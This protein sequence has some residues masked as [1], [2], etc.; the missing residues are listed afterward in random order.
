MKNLVKMLKSSFVTRMAFIATVFA[1][2]LASSSCKHDKGGDKPKPKDEVVVLTFKKG[3]NVT[4]INP[5][6]IQVPKGTSIKRS[7]LKNKIT[8]MTFAAGYE[9]D[10]LCVGA[11][12]GV[13]ITESKPLV[14]S[15]NT[16]IYVVAKQKGAVDPTL[17]TLTSVKVSGV[18]IDVADDMKAGDT[19]E[20]QVDVEFAT[21]P[22]DAT[23]S[24]SPNL[25]P[26]DASQKKGKWKLEV[27]KKTLTITVAKDG[28]TKEYSLT[29]ERL[30]A[31]APRLTS[32]KVDDV[33]VTPITDEMT[34]P[35]TQKEKVKV[36]YESAPTGTTV[37]TTPALNAGEWALQDGDNT[38]VIKVKK[39]ANEKEYKLKITKGGNVPGGDLQIT[40]ITV[41]KGAFTHKKEGDAVVEEGTGTIEI[42][43]PTEFDGVEYDL[44]LAH[45]EGATVEY[46]STDAELKT[47]LEGGKVKFGKL[48]YL[49]DLSKEF[50][51]KISKGGE[52]KTY[53]VKVIMMTNAAGFFGAR[54]NGKDTSANLDTIIKVLN[55][56]EPTLEI[57]GHEAF[58]VFVS[59]V[60]KWKT[61]LYNK[62]NAKFDLPPGAR[63]KGMG[64]K[65]I[66]LGAPGTTTDVEVII[67]NSEY[68]NDKPKEPWLATEVLKFKVK[69]TDTKADAFINQVLVNG[70]NVTN[71]EN[72]PE[73]FTAL[74]DTTPP[75][76]DSGKKASVGVVLSKKVQSV[77]IDGQAV[78]E[79]EWVTKA[80][81]GEVTVVKKDIDVDE[82]NGKEVE[83]EVTPKAEDREYYKETKMKLKLVYEVPP[84][85]YPAALDIN[86]KEWYD[87]PKGFKDAIKAGKEPLHTIDSNRLTL[88]LTFMSKP[89]K[90]TM[91]IDSTETSSTNVTTIP[92]NYYSPAKYIVEVSGVA[93]STER[94]VTLTFEPED[95]GA[96]SKGEWKFKIKGTDDSPKIKPEFRSVGKNEELPE[97]SFIKKLPE[98][99]GGAEL[100]VPGADAE[101]FIALSEYQKNAF[102]EKIT[103][104]SVEATTDEL[105]LYEGFYVSEWRLIKKIEGITSEGKD[106]T[107]VFKGKK[108]IA[109]DLTWKFKLKLKADAKPKVP[110]DKIR[111]SVGSYGVGGFPFSDEFLKGLK[112]NTEPKLELYGKDVEV[113][114]KTFFKECLKEATFKIDSEDETKVEA[115]GTYVV[116]AKHK[117]ENVSKETEH[118]IIAKV[119]PESEDYAP[120]E[121]KFKVKILDDLPEPASYVYVVDGKVKGSG[122]KA[123]LDKDFTILGFQTK[124]PVV[125]EVRMGKGETLAETDKVDL[126]E[127]KDRNGKPFW[128][129]N[130]DIDLITTTDETW[131]I[132]VTPK[133]D[134]TGTVPKVVCKYILKGTTV[135]SDNLAFQKL[136]S[137]QRVFAKVKFKDGING[138]YLDDYGAE[139][140]TFTAFTMHKDT[141]VKGQPINPIT[142]APMDSLVAVD[143]TKPEHGNVREKQGTVQAYA[144]KPTRMKLWTTSSDG[145]KTDDIDGV[146]TIGIN[147]VPLLWSYKKLANTSSG[148]LAYDVIE[149]SKKKVKNNKVYMLFAPWK[150]EFG[151]TVELD[152][153]EA[154]Q[155]KFE[156][157]GDLGNYQ[158]MFRTWLDVTNMT[159]GQEKPIKFV[160]KHTESGKVALTYT[161]KVKM[162]D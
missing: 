153:V 85:F 126:K 31:D 54:V 21:S 117:F 57:A 97:E 146:F 105:K 48:V 100:D 10:K 58:V 112:E 30:S 162:K 29:I 149:I 155:D 110:M 159:S 82:T 91:K 106:V 50:S 90:V 96:F 49:A 9:F 109:N 64:R 6:S 36:E 47:A 13:E 12:T 32:L 80:E 150:E 38:L 35:N 152:Q 119:I 158:T 28:K 71:E 139:S 53:N 148:T 55:H 113:T 81:T 83:I 103:I 157:L 59:Q 67:S 61:V 140:V 147:P 108:N 134:A 40:S 25:E 15:G 43:I 92:E 118:T 104:D 79:S 135:S 74:F 73:S 52:E 20:E 1:M 128:Y 144:D 69:T 24:F 51:I 23:L 89:K 86:E 72:D 143:L 37:T 33:P 123:T 5:A 99:V 39:D 101:I 26:Y 137:N 136:G 94:P 125:K 34:A 68:E 42:P 98:S 19:T 76:F 115:S 78:P 4:E 7:E 22:A 133:D 142:M 8:K 17:P 160:L 127:G 130:K 56:E 138:A 88:K 102:V 116:Q 132:E 121:Y 46:D 2:V 62:E 151:C 41:K 129:A 93:S 120:L 77:K 156:K 84:K 75:E 95:E 44:E 161:I 45:T 63:Y 14:A 124:D 65:G 60:A 11:E 114:F 141:K 154:G 66:A 70:K 27:G 131:K 16:D 87:L 145:T 3:A 122:Y 18:A 111:F 107:I